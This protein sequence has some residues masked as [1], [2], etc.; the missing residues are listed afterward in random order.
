MLGLAG[1]GD[2]GAGDGNVNGANGEEGDAGSDEDEEYAME[3]F[4]YISI[5][6]TL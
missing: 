6:S 4:N 1:R 5:Y 3:I 2:V